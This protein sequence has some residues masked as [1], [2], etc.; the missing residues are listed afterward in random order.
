MME[1]CSEY[2]LKRETFHLAMSHV[3]RTLSLLPGIRK[4]T[5]QLIGIAS[6]SIACK[7]EEVHIPKTADLVK[8]ADRAF[9]E[10]DIQAM[11]K[12]LLHILDWKI[13]PPT[14][15]NFLNTLINEWDHYIV[16][17]YE[18]ISGNTS[19]YYQN[20]EEEERRVQ[21]SGLEHRMITYHKQNQYSY[22]RYREAMQILDVGCLDFDIVRYKL[23]TACAGIIYL[24]V[25]KA[26]YDSSYELL[27]WDGIHMKSLGEINEVRVV[28][29]MVEAFLCRTLN[30]GSIE[31]IY[32]GIQ[33][34]QK[35]I[36]IQFSY[37]MPPVVK[38]LT[39]DEL[40]VK[41]I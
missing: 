23:A 18:G 25:N 34:F 33:Y 4:S 3:N 7:S 32:P 30:L 31:E 6:I 40:D 38:Y 22:K 14:H 5:F 41:C 15:Y 37:E 20:Y 35:F 39:K 8:S 19:E 10:D 27:R 1:V 9:N 11:E 36:G 13:Y 17:S 24:I 26:F 16:T 21:L 2:T 28:H 12:N 29:E